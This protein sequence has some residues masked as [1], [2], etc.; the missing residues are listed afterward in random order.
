MP[1][2][3]DRQVGLFDA[4]SGLR[5]GQLYVRLPERFGRPVVDVAAQHVAA[6]AVTRPIVPLGPRGPLQTQLRAH[7]RIVHQARDEAPRGARVAAQQ[8][9]NLAFDTAAVA[10]FARTHNTA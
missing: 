8:A 3:P 9:P 7:A 5:L 6:L 4:K 2:R 10:R 1:D